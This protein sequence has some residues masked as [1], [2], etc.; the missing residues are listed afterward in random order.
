MGFRCALCSRESFLSH[1]ICFSTFYV[2][3]IFFTLSIILERKRI[4]LF[5]V[6]EISPKYK[7]YAWFSIP[8]INFHDSAKKLIFICTEI[9]KFI[10]HIRLRI[11][12]I[13]MCYQYL[14]CCEHI[15]THYTFILEFNNTKIQ[16]SEILIRIYIQQNTYYLSTWYSSI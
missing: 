7:R 9:E 11:K 5:V 3:P 10:F 16:K 14:F 12:A 8:L 15:I 6:V 4:Y 1:F 2:D 13:I